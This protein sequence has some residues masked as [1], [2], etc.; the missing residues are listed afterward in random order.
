M[1]KQPHVCC[2]Q[3]QTLPRD[4]GGG[5]GG[6]YGGGGGGTYPYLAPGAQPKVKN[7]RS[8]KYQKFCRKM[9]VKIKSYDNVGKIN[10]GKD[11][12]KLKKNRGKNRRVYP[13]WPY[14]E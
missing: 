2:M 1:M 11:R 8:N 12:T 7:T 5:G 13:Q 14:C 9:E 4:Q 3:P 6:V 10:Q